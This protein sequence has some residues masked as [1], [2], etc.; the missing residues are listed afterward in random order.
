[1]SGKYCFKFLFYQC[2]LFPGESGKLS[3][4]D[5]F[6]FE[7]KRYIPYIV[8]T[9]I[10]LLT[11]IRYE[12]LRKLRKMIF[13]AL[14]GFL[15][16]IFPDVFFCVTEGFSMTTIFLI[17]ISCVV[18]VIM[19]IIYTYKRNPK[20][21]KVIQIASITLIV[22]IFQVILFHATEGFSATTIV[23]ITLTCIVT[24]TM[25]MVPICLHKGDS[26]INDH[27]E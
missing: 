12:K 8:V 24:A 18:I 3:L 16:L 5:M 26:E 2:C 27:S 9:I 6:N 11:M 19:I 22:L 4:S 1:M 21:P 23:L 25:I 7:A 20:T 15:V 14:S 13:I 10:L 17:T